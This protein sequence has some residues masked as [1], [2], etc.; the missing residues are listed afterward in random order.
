MLSTYNNI[1]YSKVGSGPHLCFLHGF[2]ENSS[3]WDDLIAHLA[4]RYTCIAIDLPGFG[5]SSQMAFGSLTQVARQ[6]HELLVS[7][8]ALH[9]IMWG[10]SLGGYILADYM[11]QCGTELRGAAFVHSTVMADS[12]EK[13]LNREKTIRFIEKNGT[14]EFFRLFIPGLVAP[15]N[16]DIAKEK[17]T[18]MVSSTPT[19]S[20]IAGLEAMKNREDK[21]AVLSQ[22][23]K[24]VLWL[25]GEEDTH[26]P[27]DEVYKLSAL[28]AISQVS[29]LEDVGHLSMLEDQ[30]KCLHEVQAFLNFVESVSGT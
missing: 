8:D 10:H 27:K 17:M 22:F 18:P 21:R 24:P 5:K 1:S 15:L 6:V 19:S 14:K 28:C 26:Y 7:E 13:K 30:K 3:I 11:E 9:T 23:K 2:C 25:K 20:I 16:V 29:V 12:A 4:L